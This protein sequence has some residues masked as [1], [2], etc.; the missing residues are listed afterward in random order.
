M[1][2]VRNGCAPPSGSVVEIEWQ[3][4]VGLGRWRSRKEVEEWAAGD[5]PCATHRS[6]GYVLTRTERTIVVVQSQVSYGDGDEMVADALSIP[7]VAVRRVRMLAPAAPGV[8]GSGPHVA[9]VPTPRE[10]ASTSVVPPTRWDGRGRAVFLAGGISGC[11]DWQ[12]DATRRLGAADVVVLNP[13]RP[14]PPGAEEAVAQ[15]EWEF[16][17]LRLAHARLFWFPA[18]SV[19]PIALFELGAWTRTN[20]PLFVGADPDYPR[21]LDIETQVRLARPDV[22]IRRQLAEVCADVTVWAH[23]VGGGGVPWT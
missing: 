16:Q 7:L 15:I 13:R 22:S 3:D 19:C 14:T 23:R 12:A 11:P 8:D 9:P 4:S 1:S 10:S 6:V 2:D 20:E 17:H 21:R 5:S 18:E